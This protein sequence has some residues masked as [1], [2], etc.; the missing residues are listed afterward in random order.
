VRI[1]I[2]INHSEGFFGHDVVKVLSRN[3]T[4]VGSGSLQHFLQLLDVHRFSKFLRDSTD[5]GRLD[6]SRVVIVEE[7][8]DLVDSI[9]H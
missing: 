6:K 8:E 5:I 1:K 9:L 4:P 3:F 7:V 2:K